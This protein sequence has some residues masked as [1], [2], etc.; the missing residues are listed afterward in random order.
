MYIKLF[1]YILVNLCAIYEGILG[2]VQVTGLGLSKHTGFLMTGS[3]TNPGPYGGFIAISLSLLGAYYFMNTDII[4]N[5]L[6]NMFDCPSSIRE[7]GCL[8]GNRCC[9]TGIWI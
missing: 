8:A 9:I 7:S 6:L 5:L 3:F 4:C 1:I 2:F